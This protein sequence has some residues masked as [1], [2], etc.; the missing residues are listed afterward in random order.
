MVDFPSVGDVQEQLTVLAEHSEGLARLLPRRPGQKEDRWLQ[1]VAAPWS[2]DA[3][4]AGDDEE[5]RPPVGGTDKDDA[6][7]GAATG[8]RSSEAGPGSAIGT[9]LASTS[10]QAFELEALRSGLASLHDEVA[11]LRTDLDALRRGLGG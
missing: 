9:A 10:E 11:A 4:T 3:G 5:A 1:I 2:P 8:A 7:G 6:E